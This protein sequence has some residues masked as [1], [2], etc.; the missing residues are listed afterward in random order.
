MLGLIA[1]LL[2]Q[3]RASSIGEYFVKEVQGKVQITNISDKKGDISKPI[4]VELVIT[5]DYRQGHI[6]TLYIFGQNL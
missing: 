1:V 3:V 5:D 4:D 6:I 2:S